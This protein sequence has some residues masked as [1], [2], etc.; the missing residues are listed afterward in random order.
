MTNS[1]SNV[2]ASIIYYTTAIS[3]KYLHWN[4]VPLMAGQ[5]TRTASY[6]T[7]HILHPVVD[8][9][10]TLVSCEAV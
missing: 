4:L 6:S 5:F 2:E 9:E 3:G 7:L 8:A 1:F 10:S